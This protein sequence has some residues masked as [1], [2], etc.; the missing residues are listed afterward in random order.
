LDLNCLQSRAF[1][2]GLI[3]MPMNTNESV[4]DLG[5]L[6]VPTLCPG[7]KSDPF[8]STDFSLFL[9]VLVRPEWMPSKAVSH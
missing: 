1:P 9:N 5:F 3:K 6:V 7:T 4:H 2:G 8:D